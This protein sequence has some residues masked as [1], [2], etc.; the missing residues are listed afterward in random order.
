[1]SAVLLDFKNGFRG[2]VRRPGF[3]FVA[4]FILALGIGANIAGFSLLNTLVL[5]IV[6]LPDADRLVTLHEEIPVEGAHFWDLSAPNYLDFKRNAT[7]FESTGVWTSRRVN[8]SREV[9]GI[10]VQA[11]RVSWDL[12]PTLG[13]EPMLGRGF[14]EL[15]DRYEGPNV[16]VLGNALWRSHFGADS[17]VLGRTILVNGS[18]YEVVGVLPTG[19]IL[20]FTLSSTTVD[21]Y[22]PI[23]FT[24]Q[25]L[26]SRGSHGLWA[27][28]RLKPGVD[29]ETADLELKRIGS[30][31]ARLYPEENANRTGAVYAIQDEAA[32]FT[33]APLAVLM[34]VVV[35]VLLIACSNIASLLLARGIERRRELAVRTAMGAGAWALIRQS[36]SESLMLGLLGGIG[37][38]AIGRM[39]MNVIPNLLPFI[40]ELGNVTLDSRSLLFALLVSLAAALVFGTLPALQSARLNPAEVLKQGARGS[41]GKQQQRARSIL[42]ILQ[43]TLATV[44]LVTAG[45]LLRSFGKLQEVDPGFQPDHLLT[46]SC[47]RADVK[48]PDFEARRALYESLATQISTLPGV[49]VAALT[50]TLPLGSFR[51]RN[52]YAVEGQPQ[53]P[54]HWLLAFERSVTNDFFSTMGIPVLRGRPFTDFDTDRDVAIVNQHLAYRHWPGQDPIGKR[55]TLSGSDRWRT[56]V[57]VVGNVLQDTLIESSTAE[58]YKPLA[59]ENRFQYLSFAVRVHGD[60]LEVAPALEAAIHEIDPELALYETRTGAEMIGRQLRIGSAG[61]TLVTGFGLLALALASVGLY[62]VVSLM[63]GLRTRE[64]VIR[65]ALGAR[66][67]D[68]LRMIL[69]GGLRRVALGTF[70]GLAV[71]FG[72][73]HGIS[74]LL[75]GVSPRD[76]TTYV[77]APL[78]VLVAA[79]LACIVPAHRAATVH[80]VK[81]LREE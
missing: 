26:E 43:I 64:I 70:I 2:L 1:M 61:T 69:G 71:A 37:G 6:Q 54:G 21:L 19:P 73:A 12:F 74:G 65:M 51:M 42:V 79:M 35:L 63:V 28:G 3:T 30:E 38:L 55:V 59:Q 78:L 25:E 50:D 16:A 44:L 31:L 41:G 40:P 58:A 14:T 10:S 8:L 32:R 24:P 15:E 57:G 49:E 81:A 39:L 53:P 48:Y 75:Y 27:V 9:K 17:T 76:L 68:V 23:A 29:V 80:P 22:V 72:L 47:V 45:L 34:A 77:A 4:V 67:S 66:V 33:R 7:S 11:G 20:P 52:T 46:T 13:V 56:V 36:M 62:G 60:P 18:S 5:G